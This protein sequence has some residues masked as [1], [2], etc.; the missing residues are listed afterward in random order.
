V[1]VD[2]LIAYAIYLQAFAA[3]GFV[4]EYQRYTRGSWRRR[5]MGWHLMTITAGESLFAIE[6]TVAHLWPHLVSAAAFR[7][8]IGV[9]FAVNALLVL[10]RLVILEWA[11]R[12]G[13]DLD[14]V[15]EPRRRRA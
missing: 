1:S 6:L 12:R 15:R 2:D 3:T 14:Q 10:S 8:S 4:V 9:V 5:I 13:V 11:Q 7:W